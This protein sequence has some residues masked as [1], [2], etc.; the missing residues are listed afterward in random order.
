MLAAAFVSAAA[1]VRAVLW[2]SYQLTQPLPASVGCMPCV[3]PWR[4][5]QYAPAGQIALL[6][7]FF[8]GCRIWV[9]R[10][11]SALPASKHHGNM[12]LQLG[13]LLRFPLLVLPV[14]WMGKLCWVLLWMSNVCCRRPRR[15]SRMQQAM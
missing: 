13:S 15:L 12:M 1:W 9:T 14:S 3:Q 11:R 8:G 6:T 5:Q 2:Q 4:L 7:E 10:R